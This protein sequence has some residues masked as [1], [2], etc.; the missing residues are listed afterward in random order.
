MHSTQ[1]TSPLTALRLASI[2]NQRPSPASEHDE[3][4]PSRPGRLPHVRAY[5]VEDNAIILDNL[6][7]SLEEMAPVRVVGSASGEA[8]ALRELDRLDQ[9]VDL[10]IIDMFLKQGSGLGVLRHLAEGHLGAKRVVLTNYA[11]ADMRERC[12]ALGAHRVFDK[13]CDLDDLFAYCTRLASRAGGCMPRGA[14]G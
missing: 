11:T 5:I 8:I 7:A 10:V 14:A 6:I 1:K 12:G 13:S 4:I 9:K 3:G 2:D